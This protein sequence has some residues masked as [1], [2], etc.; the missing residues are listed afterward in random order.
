MNAA[1]PQE[2]LEEA[3]ALSKQEKYTEA[4]LL[5]QQLADTDQADKTV[6]YNLGTAYLHD[7]R[8]AES[9]LY[10]R[11]SLKIDPSNQDAIQNLKIARSQVETE[12]IA[13]PEFFV[14]RYWDN[15]SSLISASLWAILGLLSLIAMAAGFYYWLLGKDV[16]MRRK[17]FY[18]SLFSVAI[19]LLT[20]FAGITKLSFEKS[21]DQAVVMTKVELRIGA[22]ERSDTLQNLSPGVELTILDTIENFHKVKL[23][24]QETGWIPISAVKTI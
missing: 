19:F 20:L 16:E 13:I 4:A 1:T 21:T 12:I 8:L 18:A 17:A 24:D 10:L 22:D 7:S 11:K 6:F 2:M 23:Y 3:L 14:K 5:Y 15:F 9:V